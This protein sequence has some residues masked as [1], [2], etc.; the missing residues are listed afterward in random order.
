MIIS[1]YQ[2][3]E[4]GRKLNKTHPLAR[5]L[6]GCWV[7][8]E[9]DGDEIFDLS[10]NG[11]GGSFVNNPTWNSGNIVFNGESDYINVP[12]ARV[13]EPDHITVVAKSR[14][15]GD[16]NGEAQVVA[17]DDT[18]KR[19]WQL[20]IGDSNFPASNPRFLI[21]IGN[22]DFSATWAHS[23]VTDRWYVLA[24]VYDGST[25]KLYVDGIL[26]TTTNVAG[27]LDKD[28]P[29]ITFGN[30]DTH[31]LNG[32]IQYAFI[33]NCALTASEIDRLYHK[34]FEMFEPYLDPAIFYVAAAGGQV[35]LIG[36]LAGQGA[37]DGV[38]IADRSCIGSLVGTSA[39]SGNLHAIRLLVGSLASTSTL[40]GVL[41]ALK[42][43]VG[44]IAETSSIAAKLICI[45]TLTGMVAVVSSASGTLRALRVLVGSIV[46][47]SVVA[48][49]LSIIS[50]ILLAGVIAA[51]SAASGVLQ[52]IRSCSGAIAASASFFGVA[53]V[54]RSLIGSI[55]STSALTGVLYALRSFAGSVASVSALTGILH[56]TGK[57]LIAGAVAA[58]SA[59]SGSL[60]IM[61]LFTGTI[62]GVSSIVGRLIAET[63][64]A[65]LRRIFAK[66]IERRE[67]TK[68]TERRE[69]VKD[70]E[71]RTFNIE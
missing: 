16:G 18:T 47:S 27:V 33:Y 71:R 23:V 8:N 54:L 4:R 12:T 65:A 48:G 44:A 19:N 21:F 9:R 62:T 11:N 59:M 38:L 28:G 63:V 3:P 35:A 50:Q 29:D 20:R 49:T 34:P 58:T 32:D 36:S 1:P 66:D 22:N 64:I 37:L 52:A 39:V 61:K 56:V 26:R 6:V 14:Q 13:L 51:T 53:R 5:G 70:T 43:F 15:T 40:S 10:G 60:H 7:M 25:I 17:M 55:A 69:F 45:R 46:S 68:D 42:S 57:V 67:F 24:G 31:Y 30:M 41:Q 2:K